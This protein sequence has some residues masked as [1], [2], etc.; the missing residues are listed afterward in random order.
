[1]A[2]ISVFEVAATGAKDR[3]TL[4][5]DSPQVGMV[6]H[7]YSHLEGAAMTVT[8]NHPPKKVP[9]LRSTLN[10]TPSLRIAIDEHSAR[11]GAPMSVIVRMALERFLVEEAKKA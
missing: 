9:V 2:A 6:R 3:S 11:T 8:I 10:L 1:M 7:R 5:Q 4:F